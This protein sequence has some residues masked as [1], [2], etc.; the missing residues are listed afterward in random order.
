MRS[1]TLFCVHS[2]LQAFPF[3]L[4]S[5]PIFYWLSSTSRVCVVDT[6]CVL[7]AGI[8]VFS[9]VY[10]SFHPLRQSSSPHSLLTHL[11]L[12]LRV[13]CQASVGHGVAESKKSWFIHII[14]FFTLNC[15]WKNVGLKPGN[16]DSE[17]QTLHIPSFILGFS[18]DTCIFMW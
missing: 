2:T 1:L 4:S 9:S 10:Y 14:L 15:H 13:S 16:T 11:C 3:L 5:F 18:F 7:V 6:D 17:R 8:A 12:H